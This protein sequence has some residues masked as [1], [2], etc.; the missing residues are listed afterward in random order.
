MIPLRLGRDAATGKPF[1]LDPGLLQTHLHLVGATG[2]GKTNCLHVI[3]QALMKQPRKQCAMFVIDPMGNLSEDLLR[4]IANERYCP[5]HVR[6]RLVYIEPARED[7]VLTF[8]P[9]T[10]ES[11]SHRYYRVMRAIDVTL[12]GWSAQDVAQQP[13]L[14]QWMYKAFCAAA[15]MDLPIAMCRFLL[16]PGTEEHKAILSR[17]PPELASHWGDILRA[18][19]SE[20]T[21]ILESTRNRLDPFFNSTCLRRMFGSSKS[22]FDCERFIRN[23]NIVIVNVAAY[24]RLHGFVGDA[25]GGLVL[26]E[27]VET[28][29]RLTNLEGKSVVEPTYVVMDEFQKFVGVDIEDAIPT[30]RQMGLRLLLAHQSFSQLER[31]DVDLTQM[32]WQAR[33]RLVFANNARDADIVA[34]E[35]AK[36]TFDPR[37]VKDARYSL[38]QLIAGHRKEW[39]ESVS[40]SQSSSHSAGSS[41]MFGFGIGGGQSRQIDSREFTTNETTRR[42]RQTGRTKND[43]NT[44]GSSQGRSE[45]LVPV[46]QTFRELS[47]VTYESFDEY[48]LRWGK[49]IRTLCTGEAFGTFPNDLAIPKLMIDHVPIPDNAEQREAVEKLKEKNFTSEHFITAKEADD[50]LEEYRL[51]LLRPPRIER[52]DQPPESPSGRGTPFR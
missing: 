10:Y 9:L 48:F 34:D 18:R 12:R 27:I 33:S 5:Q 32:I 50:E 20:A 7:V 40:S 31:S 37:V 4:F 22:R 47:N 39:L 29:S 15:M 28:A 11:D 8:N 21:R 1:Y 19:G 14:L 51:Q 13:R 49:E 35:L 43:A 24:G 46:H 42:Q 52:I 44:S 23:R 17:M 30:V 26:N 3:L 41:D 16:H 25:I 2:S 6:D 36:R 45:S 38:R